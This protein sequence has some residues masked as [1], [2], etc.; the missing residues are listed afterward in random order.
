MIETAGPGEAT[1]SLA[2]DID[3]DLA[4]ITLPMAAGVASFEGVVLT[5]NATVEGS[6]TFKL[7][8]TLTSLGSVSSDEIVSTPA[9]PPIDKTIKGKVDRTGTKTTDPE[10]DEDGELTG[11]EVC[12][13]ATSAG[14]I[15]DVTLCP[16]AEIIGGEVGGDISGD[17]DDPAQLTDVTILPGSTLKNVRIGADVIL[18]KGVILGENVGFDSFINVP[19]GVML[20]DTLSKIA[21]PGHAHGI[22]L[23]E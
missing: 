19:A 1:F 7:K 2:G 11:G 21:V 8:F 22:R 10:I 3:T 16:G 9:P 12:G 23:E 14:K 18:L 17:P 13:T 20:T 4:S 5:Y 6:E 15:T